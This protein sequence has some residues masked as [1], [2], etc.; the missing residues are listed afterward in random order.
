MAGVVGLLGVLRVCRC[1]RHRVQRDPRGGGPDR[2]L[3]ALQ[4]QGERSRFAR[5]RRSGHHARRL[6][7]RHRAGLV[8]AVVRRARQGHRRRHGP[9]H[10]GARVLLDRGRPAAPLADAQRAWPRGFDRRRHRVD[11]GA[12]AAGPAGP[13]GARG[14]D[15]GTVRRA[16]LL[17]PASVYAPRRRAR[18]RLTAKQ[19]RNR[20]DRRLA[21]RLYG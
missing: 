3:A 4:V 6:E 16:A 2:R 7:A 5:S 11:R 8:H 18:E 14:G 12:R 21:H 13:R 17:P 15:R 1:P 10:R 19:R 20:V 9:S